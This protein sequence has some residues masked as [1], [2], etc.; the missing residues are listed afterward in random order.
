MREEL[1]S[2]QQQII[3]QE[4]L[5][6]IGVLLSGIAH[7]LNNPLQAIAGFSEI[8]QRNKDLAPEIRADLAL[9]QKESMRASGIIRNVS[10]FSRQ[11]IAKPSAPAR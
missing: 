7:E 11:Q 8:L 10:R 2:L 1:E 3:R 9:I 5:A 4:R 6:A